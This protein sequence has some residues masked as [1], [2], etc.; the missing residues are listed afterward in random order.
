M[1]NFWT[2]TNH[3]KKL[4]ELL[5][6]PRPSARVCQMIQMGYPHRSLT[7]RPWKMV[8]GRWSF[9]IAARSL[10][11]GK[12]SNFRWD[13]FLLTHPRCAKKPGSSSKSLPIMKPF[14]KKYPPAQ[15][16]RSLPSPSKTAT[17]LDAIITFGA[18]VILGGDFIS[19]FNCQLQGALQREMVSSASL[20]QQISSQFV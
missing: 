16:L 7:V 10:F 9:P 11:R 12:L 2:K 17:F 6:L 18:K 14:E 13:T 1:S 3:H 20:L 8:V 4:Q 15:L 5:K 19:T